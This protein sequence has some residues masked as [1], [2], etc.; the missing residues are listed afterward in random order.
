MTSLASVTVGDAPEVW[1][2]L[3]FALRGD[4]VRVGGLELCLGPAPGPG[5]SRVTAV[6]E[7]PAAVDG[8]AFGW[9]PYA[10]P[11]GDEHPNGVVALDHVVAVTDDLERTTT[12]LQSAG[13][14]LRRVRERAR[15]AFLLAGPCVLEV[16][17]SAEASAAAFWG[18]AFA[19][20]LDALAASAGALVGAARDA[21]QPGR[22]IATLRSD[23]GSSVPVAFLS[24]R[25]R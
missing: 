24:E 5:V 19:G 9:T 21:V 8:L 12:A 10:S 1:S 16:T 23:A 11:D 14:V 17:E 3:G 25:T 18:L 13:F 6:G 7:G 22:R 4:R 15:Q 20:D 2:A